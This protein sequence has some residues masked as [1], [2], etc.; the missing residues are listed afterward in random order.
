MQID[1]IQNGIVIDHIKAGKSME[2]YHY[3]QLNRLKNTVAIIQN[4][5]SK[6]MGCKDIIKVDGEIDKGL[7][8]LGYFDENITINIIKNGNRSEK[9]H[10]GLP[11]EVKGVIFC[12]NPRCITMSEPELEQV[13]L[14]T[15]REKREYRC[16]YC[17]QAHK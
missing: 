13:F 14:L 9:K 12:K 3:L 11:S 6:K 5:K 2:I 16:R 10:L 1:S 15:N 7:D 8:L 17:E 4:V